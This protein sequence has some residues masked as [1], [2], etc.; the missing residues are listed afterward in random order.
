MDRIQIFPDLNPMFYSLNHT[1]SLISSSVNFQKE[2]K[3]KKNLQKGFF[4]KYIK[5]IRSQ[6]KIELIIDRFRSS[7]SLIY[8]LQGVGESKRDLVPGAE[9]GAGEKCNSAVTPTFDHWST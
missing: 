7:L 3:K 6:K 8:S 1:K 2:R 5:K 9:L 4:P